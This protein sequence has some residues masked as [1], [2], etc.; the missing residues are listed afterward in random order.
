MTIGAGVGERV[1]RGLL[2]LYPADYRDR[3]SGEMVQ[4]FHDKLRDARTGSG[5]GGTVRVWLTLLG[6]V[7]L[8]APSEHLRRKRSVAHSLSSTP[9]ISARALGV[10]GI[11]AGIVGLAVFVIEIPQELI[12]PRIILMNLG[13]IAIVL[14]VHRRQAAIAPKLALLAAVPAVF[15]NA[16]YLVMVVLS[17]LRSGPIFGGAFGLSLFWGGVALWLTTALFGATTLR[18]GAVTRWGAFATTVGALLT[19]TG[20]D[21]IGLVSEAS[22]TIFNTLSQVGIITLA[23]GWILLGLDVAIRRAPQPSS[24]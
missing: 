20:I 19:L 18:L 11:L 22:P 10:A 2:R 8:T 9:P 23:V 17:M 13:F 1:Y 15:A 6:D 21:R 7:A 4:L 14:A 12:P 16:W 5:S 3:F 24:S